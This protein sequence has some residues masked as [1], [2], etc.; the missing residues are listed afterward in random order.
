MTC[1][2]AQSQETPSDEAILVTAQRRP[3]RPEDVPIFLTA[4]SGRQLDQLQATDM[5]S[6]GK[7]VPTLV[8]TRSGAFTQAFLRGIGKRSTLGVEN[9]V[10]TYVDGVYLASSISALLDLRGITRVEVLNGPQGTLF[11][12]NTTGGVIQ[13]VTRDPEPGRLI[14]AEIGAGTDEYV[15]GD[16]YVAAGS[17]RFAGN[18]AVSLSRNGG[19]GQNLFT[20][21]ADQGEV[22]HQLV[23]R[24]KWVWRPA[25]AVKLT[26]AGDYQD[27]DQDF[28]QRP[29]KGF[30]PIGEPRVIG[31]RDG[32]QDGSNRFHFKYGGLSARADVEIGKL[33]FMSLSAYRRLVA[34]YNADL[35]LGPQP[36]FSASPVAR[37]E[38]VSQEFQLQTHAAS[39]LRWIAG[40]YYIGIEERYDPTPFSYGGKYSAMLGGRIGQTIEDK[41]RASS[42][43]AYGQASL[44]LGAATRLTGGLRY[45]IEHRSVRARGERVFDNAP[46]VRPIPGLPLLTEKPLKARETFRELTWRL[47]LDHDFS[48]ELMGFA[49][50]SRGFQSGGWNLQTPQSP[51]FGP[52]TIDAFEAGLKYVSGSGRFRADGS[53]FHYAYE[54]MQVSAFTP[55][56]SLT[57]NATSATIDGMDL[58]VEA[59]PD[60]RTS[61]T[62]GAQFLKAR[63]DKFRNATC[64]DYDPAAP[65]PY[66]PITCDATGNRLPFSPKFKFNI[67]GSR[68]L[69]LGSA[70]SLRLSA[71]AA[72]NSGYYSE[73]DNVV[74]QKAF[75]T[76]DASAEWRLNARSPALRLWAKNITG[77][78][79]YDALVTLPTAGVFQR[80]AAPR[81]IG[82]SI[83][84]TM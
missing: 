7:V 63:F 64:T 8:M 45:T 52:E 61:L 76:L 33:T 35:D 17:E 18:L 78:H 82:V 26:L 58:Q 83:I 21:R 73:A 16:A 32:D 71:N 84:M 28:S 46:F 53:V 40:L 4:L 77:T 39:R 59:R 3:E 66:A 2:P 80:P 50:A 62:L 9:S 65:V 25:E 41:G 75:A 24:S 1:Q 70:G 79:Y 69:A 5:A 81:R 47:A 20:G 22:D 68:E 67:G 15:R 49:S 30:P 51:A 48:G 54:D 55:L 29:A 11:G 6:L 43:A 38:Q 44:L 36:L 14:E 27:I 31:F 72:Y 37:Q 74:R 23:L 12:R 34:R 60:P 42:Y 57:T 56:G 19:Y 10:A 13:I